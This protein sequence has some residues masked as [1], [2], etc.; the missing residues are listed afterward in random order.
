[1]IQRIVNITASRSA[2]GSHQV[3][4]DARPLV[5]CVNLDRPET[6]PF[7]WGSMCDGAVF[8]ARSILAEVLGDEEAA[9]GLAVAYA[10][11]FVSTIPV[12]T[13]LLP[14]SEVVAWVEGK[15][16]RAWWLSRN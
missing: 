4:F 13:F 3:L 5:P 14:S 7:R 15:P 10:L 11:E 6:Q 9:A 12:N 2:D 16:A 8:L 1:V